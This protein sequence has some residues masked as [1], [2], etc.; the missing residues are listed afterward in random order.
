MILKTSDYSNLKW[1]ETSINEGSKLHK[2]NNNESIMKRKNTEI[3]IINAVIILSRVHVFLQIHDLI[4]RD[5]E[6]KR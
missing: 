2:K 1:I 6:V 4:F 3:V 5:K